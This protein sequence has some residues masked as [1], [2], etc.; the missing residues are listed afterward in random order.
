VSVSGDRGIT[1]LIVGPVRRQD[2]DL[3]P[4]FED[5]GLSVELEPDASAAVSRCK[6]LRPGVIV[7]DASEG[8]DSAL[9]TCEALRAEGIAA[10]AAILVLTDDEPAAA[11]RAYRSGATDAISGSSSSFGTLGRRAAHLVRW[12]RERS[13]LRF[14]ATRLE[15]A[16]HMAG[17]GWW[18]WDVEGNRFH[19]SD[20]LLRMLGEDGGPRSFAAFMRFVHVQDRNQILALARVSERGVDETKSLVYRLTVADGSNRRVHQ[21]VRIARDEAG[22]PTRISGALHE[23]GD[24]PRGAPAGRRVVLADFD[25][26]TG[27]PNRR[28]LMD[29]MTV[30]LDLARRYQRIAAVL[31]LDLDGFK[32]IN[33]SLGHAVGDRVLQAAGQRLTKTIRKTD[34][35]AR[36]VEPTAGELVARFGGDEFVVLLPELRRAEDAF[37]VARRIVTELARP[38]EIDGR[39]VFTTVSVG[40]AT[41]PEDGAEPELLLKHA[42]TAMY[43]VKENGKNGIRMF[44]ASMNRRAQERLEIESGLRGAISRDELTLLY[45]P[46]VTVQSGTVRGVEALLRWKKPGGRL[47][48]PADFITVVEDSS[49]ILPLGRW[50][51]ERVCRQIGEW[52]RADVSP[53]RV[54]LNVSSRQF[55]EPGFAEYI[56]Q[57]LGGHRISPSRL[58]LELTEGA[59]VKN[60]EQIGDSLAEL[61]SMGL[62]LALDDFGTGYASLNLLRRFPLDAVKIDRSFVKGLP[63]DTDSAAVTTAILMMAQALKLEVVAEGVETEEQR[64]FLTMLGCTEIQG[65]LFSKPVPAEALVSLLKRESENRAGSELLRRTPA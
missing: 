36:D 4:A 13:E 41:H 24:E 51:F 17:V 10:M 35:A 3:I 23:V 64:E 27:L 54:A 7:L 48:S 14:R 60:P 12:V 26:V 53:V 32:R 34:T 52:D 46:K 42:D 65:F 31:F 43:D 30:A 57:T 28:R 45:Q 44:T 62:R 56:A 59:L 29:R 61:K 55:E 15:R 47:V 20:G 9:E 63:G 6:A 18:E 49:L 40:I 39:E 33:D 2:E 58:E 38:Y 5:A 8:K 50:V 11:D 25:P 16:V 1:V 21:N 19:C 22:R 37:T